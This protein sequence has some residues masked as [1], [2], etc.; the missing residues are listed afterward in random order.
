MASLATASP[1]MPTSSRTSPPC[2]MAKSRSLALETTSFASGTS[3]SAPLPVASSTTPRMS[4]PSP[5]RITIDRPPS[6]PRTTTLSSKTPMENASTPSRTVTP[7][8]TGS[9]AFGSAPTI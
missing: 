3:Q 9:T 7:T 5:S 2:R 6:P 8:P 4:L 1:A